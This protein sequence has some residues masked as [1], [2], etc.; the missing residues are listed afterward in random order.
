MKETLGEKIVRELVEDGNDAEYGRAYRAL[1]L[2]KTAERVD[3]DSAIK[4]CKA[5]LTKDGMLGTYDV[6]EIE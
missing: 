2:I 5:V 6:E 1:K 3:I 4:I